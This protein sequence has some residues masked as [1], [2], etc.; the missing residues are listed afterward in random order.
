MFVLLLHSDD[1]SLIPRLDLQR[2]RHEE[3]M[4]VLRAELAALKAV[5]TSLEQK[6]GWDN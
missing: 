3:S 4:D 2:I 1:K 6:L 5:I